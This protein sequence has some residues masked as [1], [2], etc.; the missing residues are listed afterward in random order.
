MCFTGL[1]D[2]SC[3]GE[4]QCIRPLKCLNS[5]CDCALGSTRAGYMK[6]GMT[7]LERCIPDISK[8]SFSNHTWISTSCD[9]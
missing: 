4:F 1:G 3:E 6:L 7:L 9:A 5:L 8:L 2:E